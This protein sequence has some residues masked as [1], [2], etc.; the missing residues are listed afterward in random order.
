MRS[1]LAVIIL[2]GVLLVWLGPRMLLA[3]IGI[4]LLWALVGITLRQMLTPRAL[5]PPRE[6]PPVRPADEHSNGHYRPW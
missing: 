5:P 4:T 2:F 1:P 6:P 3:S